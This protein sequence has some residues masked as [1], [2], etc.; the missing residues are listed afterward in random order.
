MEKLKSNLKND[1]KILH[2]SMTYGKDKVTIDV[3][4]GISMSNEAGSYKDVL[5]NAHEALKYCSNPKFTSSY[6]FYKDMRS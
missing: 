2:G 3:N 5:K 1:E 6:L 4:M